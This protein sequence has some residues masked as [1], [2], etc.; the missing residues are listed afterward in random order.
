MVGAH[1]WWNGYLGLLYP[2]RLASCNVT[3][4]EL[5]QVVVLEG[6]EGNT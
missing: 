5:T 2:I 6:K 1:W 4:P 3:Y